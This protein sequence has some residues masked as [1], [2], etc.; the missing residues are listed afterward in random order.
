MI[1]WDRLAL[2]LDRLVLPLPHLSIL[3]WWLAIYKHMQYFWLRCIN[4]VPNRTIPQGIALLMVLQV[5]GEGPLFF[6]REM[7]LFLDD[8]KK[9]VRP[10]MMLLRWQAIALITVDVVYDLYLPI[11]M[12]QLCMWVVDA[13]VWPIADPS[14]IRDSYTSICATPWPWP[15]LLLE[16]RSSPTR[17]MGKGYLI[18]TVI[19]RPVN[20][21]DLH[22]LINDGVPDF[23][24]S[25]F[26]MDWYSAV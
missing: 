18:V 11:S 2:L 17:D 6:T 25:M 3:I 9:A 4:I 12:I 8:T 19:F 10:G 23:H 5:P 16:T 15:C 13:I 24:D 20:M 21:Q 7:K 1:S 26:G 22:T 14:C